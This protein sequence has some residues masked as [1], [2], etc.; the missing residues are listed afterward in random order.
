M[1]SGRRLMQTE[2]AAAVVAE[3][4][5]ARVH[6][7]SNAWPYLQNRYVEGYVEGYVEV[8]VER[9]TLRCTLRFALGC[10]LGYTLRGVR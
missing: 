7:G 9:C 8:Y 1:S 10:T 6:N 2:T 4:V 5:K 3:G